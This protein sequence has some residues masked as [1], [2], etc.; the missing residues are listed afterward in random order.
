MRTAGPIR[1][2]GRRPSAIIRRT[3]R[4]K[5]CQSWGKLIDGNKRFEKSFRRL[6][7]SSCDDSLKGALRRAE[8]SRQ[9]DRGFDAFGSFRTVLI[10][11]IRGISW[12]R[13]PAFARSSS[14]S[15][16]WL[17]RYRRMGTSIYR[18]QMRSQFSLRF[19]VWAAPALKP[20]IEIGTQIPNR[21]RADA[22]ENW[23]ISPPSHPRLTQP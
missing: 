7:M 23:S 22:Q 20:S 13:P 1:K 17:P 21:A 4:G 15:G 16:R 5:T 6:L 11:S 12:R 9:H 10:R 3:V 18:P 8:G 14:S 2:T 19:G